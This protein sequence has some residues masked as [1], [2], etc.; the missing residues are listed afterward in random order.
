VLV[1]SSMWVKP[2]ILP[3]RA[4]TQLFVRKDCCWTQQGL[5][6]HAPACRVEVSPERSREVARL[7]TWLYGGWEMLSHAAHE[8]SADVPGG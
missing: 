1:T 5:P 2:C 6:S 8:A 7:L 3:D 4:G